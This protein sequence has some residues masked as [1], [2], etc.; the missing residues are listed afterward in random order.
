MDAAEGDGGRED[1]QKN[2][3]VY[4]RYVIGKAYAVFRDK[5]KGKL[6]REST[7]FNVERDSMLEIIRPIQMKLAKSFGTKWFRNRMSE[8]RR[9]FD[10]TEAFVMAY[11]ARAK[12]LRRLPKSFD[13]EW[14]QQHAPKGPV[15]H[16][17]K[18]DHALSEKLCSTSKALHDIID[19]AH[20]LLRQHCEDKQ[21]ELRMSIKQYSSL[22]HDKRPDARYCTA[23][24][25]YGFVTDTLNEG[26]ETTYSE[27][28]DSGYFVIRSV[29]FSQLHTI[30]SAVRTVVTPTE[31][32]VEESMLRVAV[33]MS[34][35]ER[36]IVVPHV[37]P[38]E[39]NMDK[40]TYLKFLTRGRGFDDNSRLPKII[41]ENAEGVRDIICDNGPLLAFSY[42]KLPTPSQVHQ[43]HI[44]A[45]SSDAPHCYP[46]LAEEGTSIV[47]MCT[48]V[49]KSSRKSARSGTSGTSQRGAVCMS[50]ESLMGSVYWCV[51]DHITDSISDEVYL[52]ELWADQIIAAG[53]HGIIGEM[54]PP[55]GG[56]D[57]RDKLLSLLIGRMS[58]AFIDNRSREEGVAR[59]RAKISRGA[60]EDSVPSAFGDVPH[61]PPIVLDLKEAIL[62]V[63]SYNFTRQIELEGEDEC[64]ALGEYIPW[65]SK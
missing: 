16:Q 46:Q 8:I 22:F 37:S 11:P 63:A 17:P 4:D 38:S 33:H 10:K 23:K 39:R 49:G 31:S 55:W 44:T 62:S 15:H 51:R 13:L 60:D 27:V 5:T 50:R 59:K 1:R 34:S 12:T 3:H 35:G 42:D 58:K 65:R 61:V 57:S 45:F 19:S 29:K 24:E 43:F 54:Y 56:A 7:E 9:D 20:S 53:R 21:T 30:S 25:L 40:V 26:Q 48:V 47:F 36:G 18:E 2:L 64:L 32:K 41:E 14:D 52:L 6:A 28:P